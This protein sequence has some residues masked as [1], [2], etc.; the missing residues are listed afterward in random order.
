MTTATH[1]RQQAAQCRALAAE[2]CSHQDRDD[3]LRLAA[4]WE[5]LAMSKEAALRRHDPPLEETSDSPAS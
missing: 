1:Y 4:D 2:A 3:L 5:A